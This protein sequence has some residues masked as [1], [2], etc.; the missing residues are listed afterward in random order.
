MKILKTVMLSGLT[1]VAAHVFSGAQPSITAMRAVK[2]DRF[3]E[4]KQHA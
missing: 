4:F 2:A 3:D 1:C